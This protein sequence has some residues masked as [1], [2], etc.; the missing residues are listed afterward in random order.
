MESK[1]NQIR[2]QL[3]NIRS[4]SPG[5]FHLSFV[6]AATSHVAKLS[7]CHF[8]GLPDAVYGLPDLRLC[9]P[10]SGGTG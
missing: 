9:S 10:S 4:K 5:C 7:D 1:I 2:N 6:L 8:A 3:E